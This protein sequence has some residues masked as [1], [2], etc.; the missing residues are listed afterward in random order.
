MAAVPQDAD[1]VLPDAAATP[2]E[3]PGVLPVAVVVVPA[4]LPAETPAVI[5]V[6]A[7]ITTMSGIMAL[8]WDTAEALMPA[9]TAATIQAI[10]PVTTPVTMPVT[11]RAIMPVTVK[12][13]GI[14]RLLP[15]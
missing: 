11:M 7:A 1:A 12:A 3:M 10:M 13:A 8:K 6:D 5:P 14:V 9:V 15:V 2:A 4:A